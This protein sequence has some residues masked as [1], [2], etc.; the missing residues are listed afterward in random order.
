MLENEYWLLW[1]PCKET[2]NRWQRPFYKAA[3][4]IELLAICW[5]KSVHEK[6]Q[7]AFDKGYLSALALWICNG[8][9][10][11]KSVFLQTDYLGHKFEICELHDSAIETYFN[12]LE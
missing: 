8:S 11:Q 12:Y 4:L 2:L 9:K 7:S 3:A 10:V 5:A 1:Q 6:Q